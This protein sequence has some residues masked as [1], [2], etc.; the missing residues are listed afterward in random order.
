MNAC[1]SLSAT[2]GLNEQA[3]GR[4][5][6]L[7]ATKFNQSLDSRNPGPC[8]W[9]DEGFGVLLKPCSRF[10]PDTI[11]PVYLGAFFRAA[12]EWGQRGLTPEAIESGH[13]KVAA[14]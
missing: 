12:N 3:K 11:C 5:F 4:D 14:L 6:G 8:E 7:N 10:K 2:Q 13:S 9:S 1:L